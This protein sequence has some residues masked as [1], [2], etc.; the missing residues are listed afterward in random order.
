VT[1][2]PNSY[3]GVSCLRCGDPIPVSAKVVEIQDEIAR[4]RTGVPYAFLARCRMCEYE[5]IYEI[6]N[7]QRFDGE[8]RRRITRLRAA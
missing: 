4:G 8:P 3:P 2:G 6:R 1:A 5:S 7:V